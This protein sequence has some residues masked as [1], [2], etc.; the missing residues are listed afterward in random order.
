MVKNFPK[1]VMDSNNIT[2]LYSQLNLE[3]SQD[4]IARVQRM[5]KISPTSIRELRLIIARGGK[6]VFKEVLNKTTKLN[7]TLKNDLTEL[8]NETIN[9]KLNEYQKEFEYVNKDLEL[10]KVQKS[11]LTKA[12][13]Q[14]Y[15]DLKSFNKYLANSSRKTYTEIV[16]KNLMQ[17]V[18]GGLTIDEAIKRA[19]IEIANSGLILK[20]KNNKNIQPDVSVRRNI[21]SGIQQCTNRINSSIAKDIGADGYET[22]AH[23]G[24]R[25]T[26]QVWQGR[27]FAL[28]Q[29]GANRFGLEL[30]SKYSHELND[31]N[32]R[33]SANPIILGISEPAY[34]D[35]ELMN[36]N[37]ETVT[38]NGN[39][40]SMYEATQKQRYFENKIRNKKRTLS[41]LSGV[42]GTEKERVRL[43]N[44]IKSYQSKLRD[45]CRQTGLSRDYS[46]EQVVY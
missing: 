11:I 26:H 10:S 7:K 2:K 1:E 44:S 13:S 5:S 40:I 28:T 33:H 25:P 18:T 8:Y 12:I 36:L 20:D 15:K 37:G 9:E 39:N 31:Y 29:E 3:L 19:S 27:Q 43:Q 46:R 16:E 4:L 38:Y 24:A 41:S 23:S 34:N 42:L 14:N 45:L 35:R 6:D 30:W 21:S 17:V 32:C 22:S